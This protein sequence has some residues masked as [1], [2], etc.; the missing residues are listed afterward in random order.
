MVSELGGR[1]G[2]SFQYGFQEVTGQ[3]Q[4]HQ[5]ASNISNQNENL[6]KLF[7]GQ[8]NFH[9]FAARISA[10]PLRKHAYQGGTFIL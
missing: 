10:T 8:R 2:V 9:I 4:R 3:A 6:R 1:Q 5:K 7:A